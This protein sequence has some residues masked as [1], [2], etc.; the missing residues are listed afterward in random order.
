MLEYQ[1]LVMQ[2]RHLTL[3]GQP[4]NGFFFA[5]DKKYHA[6]HKYPLADYQADVSAFLPM[7]P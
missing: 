7:L 4:H 2:V 6:D 3:D 1:W 5:R